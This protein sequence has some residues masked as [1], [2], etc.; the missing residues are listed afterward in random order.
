MP[1]RNSEVWGTCVVFFILPKFFILTKNLNSGCA[2]TDMKQNLL[3]V[4][5]FWIFFSFAKLLNISLN[6]YILLLS[7][8]ESVFL[9]MIGS[10]QKTLY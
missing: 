3:H 8:V 6:D 10:E 5:F 2:P 1:K 4:M 7:H 9:M